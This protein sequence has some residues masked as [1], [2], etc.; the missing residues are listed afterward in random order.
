MSKETDLHRSDFLAMVSLSTVLLGAIVLMVA[1]AAGVIANFIRNLIMA[2]RSGVPVVI[3][4]FWPYS[5][6]LVQLLFLEPFNKVFPYF[7]R[8]LTIS[9]VRF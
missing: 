8:T 7:R 1:L 6:F 9:K 5:M 4:V 3:P 2:Y